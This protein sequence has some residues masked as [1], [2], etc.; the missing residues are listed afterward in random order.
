MSIEQSIVFQN[1]DD[2]SKADRIKSIHDHFNLP[3]DALICETCN[4][5][6]DGRTVCSGKINRRTSCSNNFLSCRGACF[7]VIV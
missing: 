4:L 5:A 6:K 7:I 2:L 3:F 1:I